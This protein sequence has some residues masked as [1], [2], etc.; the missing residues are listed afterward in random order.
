MQT[1][2]LTG[3]LKYWRNDIAQASFSRPRDIGTAFETLCIDFLTHDPL[4][5]TQLENVH[6]FADWAKE[7]GIDPSDTGVD[8]V[9]DLRHRAGHAAVQCE[10]RTS[11]KSVSKAEINSFLSASSRT[12]F[13][14][15]III[16]K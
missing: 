11:G 14:H 4:Q 10:L 13:T 6:R 16:D 1:H 8:L 12:E 5:A 2:P 7:R 3:I 9:A 15:R